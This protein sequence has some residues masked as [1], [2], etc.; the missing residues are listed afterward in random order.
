MNSPQEEREA[1]DALPH[2]P[3]LARRIAGQEL[4][5]GR[6]VRI[7]ASVTTV[8]AVGG[9]VLIWLLDK[10]DFSS[11]G[12]GIWW[13][14]QTVTTVGYGDVV[15][16]NAEG[17]IIAAVVMLAGIGF[18]AVITAAVTASL[19]ESARKGERDADFA[20]ITRELEGINARLARMEGA[21]GAPE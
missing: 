7:I 4:T 5:A 13:S 16:H 21:A 6:A 19:I 17:R 12:Q 2:A 10:R 11:V 14:L 18:I 20:R 9:G 3:R 1:H 15:P 8:A